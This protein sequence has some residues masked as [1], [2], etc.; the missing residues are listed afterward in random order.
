[1][2]E[3]LVSAAYGRWTSGLNGCGFNIQDWIISIYNLCRREDRSRAF[4]LGLPGRSAAEGK[5]Y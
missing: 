3:A 2:S 1:V 5:L 4:F